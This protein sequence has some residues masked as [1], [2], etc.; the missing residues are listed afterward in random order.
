MLQHL[1]SWNEDYLAG[2]SPWELGHPSFELVRI[3]NEGI[4][5]PC[6]AIELGC[7][8]GTDAVFLAQQGFDVTAAD[9]SGVA[10]DRAR[11][12]ADIESVTVNFLQADLCRFRMDVE[13]FD[14]L[15]ERSCY[16]FA[17]LEN[18]DGY[19]DTVA[20]LTRAGSCY[21]LLCGNSS[22]RKRFGPPGVFEND[23]RAD[24]EELF[25]I[26]WLYPLLPHADRPIR[27]AGRWSCLM[28]R[29]P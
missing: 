17:R 19:R 6:R 18:L 25:E 10:L 2:N 24:W 5:K 23:I 15:F 3:I 13:P 29:R 8:T 12:T 21:L 7:G 11:R 4:V 26:E 20:R 9:C 14:F 27:G 16:E 22:T 1:A 28:V